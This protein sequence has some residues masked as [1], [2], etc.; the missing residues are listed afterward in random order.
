MARWAGEREKGRW[1]GSDLWAGKRKKEKGEE[2][3]WCL[4]GLGMVWL[5]SRLGL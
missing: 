4:G 1:V 2:K 3:G 5:R